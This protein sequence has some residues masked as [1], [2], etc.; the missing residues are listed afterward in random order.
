MKITKN[1]APRFAWGKVWGLNYKFPEKNMSVLYANL[2]EVHGE[3]T[4][5]EMERYY[6]ILS[7]D[8][9]FEIEGKKDQ[10]IPGDVITIPPK[11]KYNYWPIGASMEV[12][13]FMEYWDST[14]WEK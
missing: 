3:V 6:Y 13:L 7:G 2:E 14:K 9:E 4:T 8:G 5:N 11:T 12:I 10:V 1:Q